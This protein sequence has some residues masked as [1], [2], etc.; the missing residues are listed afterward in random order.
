MTIPAEDLPPYDRRDLRGPF[1]LIGDVHGCDAELAAILDQL[2]YGADNGAPL[3]HPEGRTV[4]FLGD[5]VDRGPRVPAVIRRVS[6][7]LRAGSALFV[8]GNHDERLAAYLMGEELTPAYGME[9]TIAQLEALDAG[10][11]EDAIERFLELYLAAPPYLWLD[12]GKL[13]AVHGG[14]EEEMIGTFD[15]AIWHMCLQGKVGED[16]SGLGIPRRID[17]ARDYR[18]DALVAYAHTPVPDAVFVHNTIN[19][20]QGCVFGAALSA[21]RYPE[22]E[23][24]HVDAARPYY[25]PAGMAPPPEGESPER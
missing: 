2:G 10:T 7:L 11:R 15:A 21:L 17:W 18:G 20:D 6:E 3:V 16:T 23:V 4:V 24:V 19:L 8:P 22:L 9:H 13:V 25:L 12:D 14:L 1:D 5:I